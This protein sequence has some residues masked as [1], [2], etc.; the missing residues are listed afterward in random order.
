[1]AKIASQLA[2]IK[3]SKLVKNN[4]SENLEVLNDDLILSVQQVIEQ[5]LE[6][7]NVIVEVQIDQNSDSD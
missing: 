6:E 7:H 4:E 5:L 1:M 2:F 3:V